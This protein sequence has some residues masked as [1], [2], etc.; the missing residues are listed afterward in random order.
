MDADTGQELKTERHEDAQ[1][2]RPSSSGNVIPYLNVI[3]VFLI[4][5]CIVLAFIYLYNAAQ[6][7]MSRKVKVIDKHTFIGGKH[8]RRFDRCTFEFEDGQRKEYSVGGRQYDLMTPGECGELDTKG[9]LFWDFR[10]QVRD[11]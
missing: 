1:P 8:I 4:G 7:T 3:T 11:V 5:A 2:P 9:V 6:P 10:H